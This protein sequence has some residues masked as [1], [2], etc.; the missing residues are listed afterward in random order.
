MIRPVTKSDAAQLVNIYGY[1]VENTA[2]TAE[3]TVPSVAEFEQRI[4][5][6]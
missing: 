6:T 2:I 3:L 1:Y 4:E 5:K